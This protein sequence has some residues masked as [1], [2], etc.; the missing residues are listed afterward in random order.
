MCDSRVYEYL[1]P[2]YVLLPPLSNSN[3]V[4]SASRLELGSPDFE[5][6]TFSWATR[7]PSSSSAITVEEEY[8]LK[9]KWRIGNEEVTRLREFV[10]AFEGTH[11]FHNYT[12]GREFS[13]RAA[14]RYMIKIDVRLWL[15]QNLT[16][17]SD[18]SCNSAYRWTIRK[19]MVIQNGLA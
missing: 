9:K 10:K 16:E 7:A 3:I 17:I 1:F 18:V 15:L 13:D 8:S 4:K 19:C 2:T 5:T 12:L 11:N 6:N 14:M